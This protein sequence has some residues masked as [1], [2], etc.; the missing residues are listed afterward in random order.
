MG[1]VRL[2][3]I[4]DLHLEL[5][6]KFAPV[7][8][9]RFTSPDIP[10]GPSIGPT[11]DI[12]VNAVD[13]V[14]LAGDI[15][16]RTKGI[17]Y[18]HVLAGYL[19]VPVVYVAGNHEFYGGT[20]GLT[21]ELTRLGQEAEGVHYLENSS[22]E[23]QIAGRRVVV[24]GATLWTDFELF[25]KDRVKETMAVAEKQMTDYQVIKASSPT[26]ALLPVDTME[27]H[28][29]SRAYLSEQLALI[30][31]DTIAIVMTHHAP[32]PRSITPGRE[33]DLICA[34]YASNMEAM[35]ARHPPALWVHGH[36]HWPVSYRLHGTRVVSHPFG[37][38]NERMV[39]APLILSL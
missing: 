16:A 10:V 24:L 15:D 20:L 4:S 29:D 39:S 30:E 21:A 18:A 23:F 33:S 19:G 36:T 17:G 8:A 11:L 3:I 25:G 35:I 22:A 1:M 34:A 28:Y 6:R 13:L 9:F 32:S 7:D 31:P 2:G 27:L 5:D 38:P 12:L 37:Y 26:R 14:L